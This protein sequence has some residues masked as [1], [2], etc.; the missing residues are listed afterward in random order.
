MG[1]II[2]TL[3]GV[4]YLAAMAYWSLGIIFTGE[5]I[6]SAAVGVAILDFA[7]LS[8]VRVKAALSFTL[9]S[10]NVSL[11]LLCRPGSAS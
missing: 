11:A 10:L 1:M 9:F 3:C 6:S 5:Q 4:M 7:E 2:P 8:S